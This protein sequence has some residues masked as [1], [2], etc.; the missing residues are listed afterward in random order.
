[1]RTMEGGEK[2]E[3]GEDG[4]A[5]CEALQEARVSTEALPV[6]ADSLTWSRPRP[7]PSQV[8]LNTHFHPKNPTPSTT[9]CARI[10]VP[11]DQHKKQRKMLNPAFSIAHL[12]ET[13]PIMYDVSY[14]VSQT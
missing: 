6:L 11:G 4:D 5:G 1:M 2:R 8:L 12:R 9:P 13:L 7:V 14:R 10:V 3:R